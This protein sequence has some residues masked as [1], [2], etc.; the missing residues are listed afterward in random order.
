MLGAPLFVV[1][2]FE[3]EGSLLAALTRRIPGVTADAIADPPVEVGGQR[4][5]PLV[6]LVRGVPPNQVQGLLDGMQKA[7]R[8]VEVLQDD[9]VV[10]RLLVRAHVPVDSIPSAGIQ[11]FN[12][13]LGPIHNPWV[14]IDDGTFYIRGRVRFPKEAEDLAARLARDMKEAGVEA[15]VDVQAIDRHDLSVWE[16]LVEATLGLSR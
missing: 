7:G 12:K 9:R 15:Q 6:V 3:G 16:E 5:L 1:A 13:Y 2:E 10:E 11:A 4:V 14:H 8:T